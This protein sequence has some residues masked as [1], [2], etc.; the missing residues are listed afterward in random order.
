MLV[1][2]PLH[3]RRP[4]YDHVAGRPHVRALIITNPFA[5]EAQHAAIGHNAVLNFVA[6]E[7]V[8]ILR[9]A[10]LDHDRDFATFY[11]HVADLLEA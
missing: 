7:H 5:G 4:S 11:N 2:Q 9:K 8:P 10:M 1:L 6:E 3:I